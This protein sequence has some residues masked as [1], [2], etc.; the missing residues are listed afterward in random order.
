MPD[1]KMRKINKESSGKNLNKIIIQEKVKKN[2]PDKGIFLNPE[3][4]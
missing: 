4:F 3:Y 2:P 1:K